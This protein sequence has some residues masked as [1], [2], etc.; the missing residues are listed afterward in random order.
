MLFTDNETNAERF[1]AVLVEACFHLPHPS[2]RNRLAAMLEELRIESLATGDARFRADVLA[3]LAK[4]SDREPDWA[5]ACL[6]VLCSRDIK[7]KIWTY[8]REF[9]T[10]WRRSDGKAIP[11]VR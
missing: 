8:D 7:L 10:T 9:Q 4:Y 5:D 2:Q 1:E 3:W 11:L 6:A